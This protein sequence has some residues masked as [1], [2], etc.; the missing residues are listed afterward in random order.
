M[1]KDKNSKEKAL[2][3]LQGSGG[4]QGVRLK[5]PPAI[6]IANIII[7]ILGVKCNSRK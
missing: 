6:F 5:N 4:I 7:P 1:N 3:R 2:D